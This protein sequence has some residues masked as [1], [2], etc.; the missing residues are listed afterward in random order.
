[1]VGRTRGAPLHA[2]GRA[3]PPRDAD[4]N[5]RPRGPNR[6]DYAL[7]LVRGD[8][9]GLPVCFFLGYG[10]PPD[11]TRR[12]VELAEGEGEVAG[13]LLWSWRLSDSVHES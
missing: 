2:G 4:G 5:P 9:P 10:Q 13:Y 8:A 7:S 1:M 3:H 12:N 11:F 6:I